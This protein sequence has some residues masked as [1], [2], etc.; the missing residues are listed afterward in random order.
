VNAYT[1]DTQSLFRYLT[2]QRR[3]LSKAA[4]RAF[5]EADRGQA[6]IYIPTMALC[7]MWMV[8]HAE[9]RLV[10]F[11]R[12]LEEISHTTQ[13]VIVPLEFEDVAQFDAFAAIPNDH[14]RIIAITAR[15]MDAPLITSDAE[16]IASG[17][18]PVIC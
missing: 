8:N 3:R 18:V 7:E 2:R 10:D 12:L 17:L 4:L 9:S 16:I 15:R 6:I 1:A 13:F 11:P 5:D 14:D